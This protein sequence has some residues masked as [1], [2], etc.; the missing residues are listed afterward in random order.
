MGVGY[1]MLSAVNFNFQ[2]SWGTPLTASLQSIAVTGE[3][4]VFE[5]EQ[6]PEQSM[7]GRFAE[8]PYHMGKNSVKGGFK[9]EAHPISIMWP[10]GAVMGGVVT[11]SGTGIGTH[12]YKMRAGSDW[13]DNAAERPFTLQ[14]NRNR[15]NL[16]GEQYHD[17]VGDSLT[18]N[19]K[20]GQFLTLDFAAIG[21][22]FT[23]NSTTAAP[24]YP[25]G[26]PYIWDASSLSWSGNLI[27]D[28]E[29]LTITVK[30]NLA[31]LWFLGVNTKAPY[32]IK[33]NGFQTIEVAGSVLYS[34][35]SVF[36]DFR[37]QTEI[38]MLANFVGQQTPNTLLFDFPSLRLKT[39][40]PTAAGPGMVKASFTGQAMYNTASTYAVAIT[41]VNSVQY[42]GVN[43]PA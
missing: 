5:L 31:P 23:A 11:T 22:G 4:I 25:A 16:V 18:F 41:L 8:S 2:N 13:Q 29:D 28:I 15:V 21:A 9:M 34:T 12:I 43:S 30:N 33:R 20:N 24:T 35:D 17:M 10:L 36:L 27:T 42:N 3:N 1:G 6:L 40:V 38:R 7:Y 14:V 19:I 37:N 39:F 32:K 26:K